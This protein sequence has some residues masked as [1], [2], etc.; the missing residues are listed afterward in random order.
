[1]SVQIGDRHLERRN[2]EMNPPAQQAV[3]ELGSRKARG[4]VGDE[5]GQPDRG[6]LGRGEE[7]QPDTLQPQRGQ[8]EEHTGA[9]VPQPPIV[10]D[11]GPDAQ[12]ERG[13]V[14]G[15]VHDVGASPDDDLA[16]QAQVDRSQIGVG[17]GLAEL[18][19]GLLAVPLQPRAD[20]HLGEAVAISFLGGLERQRELAVRGLHDGGAIVRGPCRRTDPPA[21]TRSR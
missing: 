14:V 2:L 17:V 12:I 21:R 5:L 15:G 1:M 4:A 13:Q 10:L 19:Q 16:P 20:P 3:L 8:L 9:E 11:G 6:Q 7:R 18:D